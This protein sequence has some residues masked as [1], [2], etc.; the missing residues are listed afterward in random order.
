[1]VAGGAM[2][3]NYLP[4]DKQQALL[5]NTLH[6]KNSDTKSLVKNQVWDVSSS[7]GKDSAEVAAAY[8]QLFSSGL[9]P[10]AKEGTKEYVA[11]L[12]E[13][14]KVLEAV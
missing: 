7:T 5:E 6:A 4:F 13:A 11:Q 1:M 12:Q 3:N 10:T 9:A 14:K 8:T 2:I